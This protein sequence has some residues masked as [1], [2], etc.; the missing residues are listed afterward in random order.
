MLNWIKSGG[1]PYS[2]GSRSDLYIHNDSLKYQHDY[3]YEQMLWTRFWRL[4]LFLLWE[5]EEIYSRKREFKKWEKVEKKIGHHTHL[6]ENEDLP[7]LG[8][9]ALR[10]KPPCFNVRAKWRVKLC[11]VSMRNAILR[12]TLNLFSLV[13]QVRERRQRSEIVSDGVLP[14][15]IVFPGQLELYVTSER[16]LCWTC[17]FCSI[18]S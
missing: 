17:K 6:R 9:P 3:I 1:S 10:Q 4:F 18:Q 11:A 5:L 15:G 14:C 7:Q 8:A 16:K 13:L 2:L 12:I